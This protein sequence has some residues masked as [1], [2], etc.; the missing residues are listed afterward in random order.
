MLWKLATRLAVVLVVCLSTLTAV[1]TA[2]A[3]A[4]SP[5]TAI[6][7]SVNASRAAYGLRPLLIRP[8]LSVVAKNWALR[9][10]SVNTLSHN[11]AL[12]TQVRRLSQWRL[13]GE[14]VGFGPTAS[15]VQRAFMRSAPHRANILNR[16]FTQIGV[17]VVVAR[18]RV[19]VTQVFLRP[20]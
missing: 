7:R 17:G 11:P 6:A 18:G 20:G 4:V 8:A 5:A 15:S 12:T 16:S 2:Q 9:M 13:V 14:N 3:S 10:A 1:E 19:W